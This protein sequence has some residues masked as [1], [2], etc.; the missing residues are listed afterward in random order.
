MVS[1]QE[2]AAQDAL[3]CIVRGLVPLVGLKLP[4]VASTSLQG[5][6]LD[7][8]GK[9]AVCTVKVG[10]QGAAAPGRAGGIQQGRRG[11][12]CPPP[13][14]GLTTQPHLEP[15]DG[16]RLAESSSWMTVV[17]A[18]LWVTL[19]ITQRLSASC[20]LAN[21]NAGPGRRRLPTSL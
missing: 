9:V 14:C 17:I 11:R 21:P 10:N 16:K 4:A 19:I 7:R 8:K 6:A 2:G 5:V 13:P 20:M 12:M 15:G 18:L 1:E 3:A